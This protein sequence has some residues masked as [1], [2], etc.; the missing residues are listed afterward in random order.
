MNTRIY[1]R[2]SVIHVFANAQFFKNVFPAALDMI[3]VAANRISG[4]IHGTYIHKFNA[5]N[6]IYLAI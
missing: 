5:V 3:R 4:Q 1:I 6:N 2:I